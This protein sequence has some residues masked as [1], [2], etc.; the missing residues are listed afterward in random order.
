[1]VIMGGSHARRERAIGEERGRNGEDIQR[2]KDKFPGG[3]VK[4]Y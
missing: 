1:M 4:L 2:V 3:S